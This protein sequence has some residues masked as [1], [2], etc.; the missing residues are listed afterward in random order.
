[1]G[2]SAGG[3]G[4]GVQMKAEI[5]VLMPCYN[6]ETN[7][8]D[9][10][11]S[12]EAQTFQN[13]EL[14]IV[15]DGSTDQTVARIEA[16]IMRSPFRP[17]IRLYHQSNQDQLIALQEAARHAEGRFF[18]ILHADDLLYDEKSLENFL[19][20]A[21][22]RPG[23]D[24]YTG[25]RLEIDAG[26]KP[27]RLVQTRKPL[28]PSSALALLALWLGRN[29]YMDCAFF[30]REAFLQHVRLNYLTWNLPFWTRL[31]EGEGGRTT[32]LSICNMGIPLFRYRIHAG[33][34]ANSRLGAA[35]V[36]S[37]EIRAYLL[38][39]SFLHIPCYPLQYTLF[40]VL[41]KLRPAISYRPLS[42]RR[43]QKRLAAI[44]AFIYRKAPDK[45]LARLLPF[46]SILAFFRTR[47]RRVRRRTAAAALKRRIPRLSESFRAPY[48][49]EMRAFNRRVLADSLDTDTQKLLNVLSE[50][51]DALICDRADLPEIQRFLL[52]LGL[53]PYVHLESEE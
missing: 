40:R 22:E 15:N 1:M 47:E 8:V 44:V 19:R 26:G 10:I 17:R 6:A 29:I 49:A 24:A 25:S 43:Q 9:A 14:I 32:C 4:T 28:P 11:G 39:A 2:N 27:L 13:W 34:Y 30:E 53:E 33:N 37:G 35:N 48:G 23:Y 7:V 52:Y 42:R 21:R 12:L 51:P 20:I 46:Q 31:A 41:N 16:H 5:S 3:S 38:L 36:L 50:G 18:Y 45:G